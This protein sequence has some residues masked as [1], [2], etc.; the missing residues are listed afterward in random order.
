MVSYKQLIEHKSK[1][2]TQKSHIKNKEISTNVTQTGKFLKSKLELIKLW[3]A[4]VGCKG[5]Y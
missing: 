5:K 4:R 3:L 1:S 2:N